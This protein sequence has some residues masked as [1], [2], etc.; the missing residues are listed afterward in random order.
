M[1]KRLPFNLMRCFPHSSV[2]GP[3]VTSCTVAHS[4]SEP[5]LSIILVRFINCAMDWGRIVIKVAHHN[6]TAQYQYHRPRWRYQKPTA[7]N[8]RTFNL[9]CL[10]FKAVEFA[11]KFAIAYASTWV[12]QTPSPNVEFMPLCHTNQLIF[13]T[14]VITRS[15]FMI[16]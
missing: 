8:S 14:I 13:I 1:F 16:K 5:S 7:A 3:L 9:C 15:T 12:P 2:Q 10:L 4:T 6:A 11:M